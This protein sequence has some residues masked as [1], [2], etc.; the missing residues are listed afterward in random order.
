MASIRENF[1][2]LRQRLS[3]DKPKRRAFFLLLL[4]SVTGATSCRSKTEN[5]AESEEEARSRTEFTERVENFFEFAPLKAGEVSPFLI[6]LTDLADGSPVENADV[7]LTIR[8]K[9]GVE[10]GDIK[11]KVGRVTGIYVADVTIKERGNYDIEFQI[12]NA[13][14]NERMPLTDFQVE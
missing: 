14:L 12:K 9:N 1:M 13:K 11:A 6:H 7:R 3:A 8:N 2:K 10:V 5:N 4:L